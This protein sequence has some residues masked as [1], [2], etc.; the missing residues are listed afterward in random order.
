MPEGWQRPT[1]LSVVSTRS[2]P[3]GREVEWTV[4]GNQRQV[5]SR[6]SDA[7]AH[8]YEVA[9]LGLEEAALAFLEQETRQ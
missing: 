8:V 1:D 3:S 5:T 2:A 9:P 6:L 7:G 4:V